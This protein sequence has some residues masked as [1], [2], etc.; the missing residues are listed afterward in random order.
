MSTKQDVLAEIH[1]RLRPECDRI[2]AI[3]NGMAFMLPLHPE[4]PEPKVFGTV[5][6]DTHLPAPDVPI[7]LLSVEFI[8]FNDLPAP[9]PEQAAE[10]LHDLG[11]TAL[12]GTL[13]INR[14][15]QLCYRYTCTV[16]DYTAPQAAELFEL[17]CY[18][19]LLFLNCHY[20]YLFICATDP[21]RLTPEEYLLQLM[22]AADP[23]LQDQKD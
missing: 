10:R 16:N 9:P 14:E 6:L 23:D 1:A 19:M 21:D 22:S 7:H 17:V 3:P 2:E 13:R 5:T 4:D 20:D 18:E 12:F 8:L 11:T 15:H